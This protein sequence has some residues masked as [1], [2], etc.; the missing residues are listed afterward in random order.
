M[1]EVTVLMP[2][3]NGLPYVKEAIASVQK[4]T[5]SDWQAIIIDDGSTD[6][7]LAYLRSLDDPRIRIETRKNGGPAAATNF[8]LSLVTTPIIAR[9][10]ADDISHPTRFAEQLA[11]LKANPEVGLVGTQIQP[12]G[13]HRTGKRSHLA[14]THERICADLRSGQHAMCNPTIMIRTDL[15]KQVGGYSLEGPLEDW[16][17]FLA[18]ARHAKLAN[19][20]RVLLSY[21]IHNSHFNGKRLAEVRACIDYACDRD[22]RIVSNQEIL[23]YD[24]F[25]A[26]RRVRPLWQRFPDRMKTTAMVQYRFAQ[27][28][29]LGGHAVR[30]FARLA[31]AATLAP[32]V[33]M[34]RLTRRLR[35]RLARS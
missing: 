9:M 12:F 31:M 10:D 21:R 30:G 22:Q 2:V 15:L 29:I 8:G 33:T 32:Q 24:A 5:L 17:M 4:Q 35:N 34:H 6:G 16:A 11:F 3:Y 20:D 25:V 7:T 27:G 26:E 19:L 23:S 13:T 18:A 28:E 1:A 14:L